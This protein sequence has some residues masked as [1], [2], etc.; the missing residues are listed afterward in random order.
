MKKNRRGLLAR[1]NFT[2][3]TASTSPSITA[4]SLEDSSKSAGLDFISVGD[5]VGMTPSRFRELNSNPTDTMF[6][7]ARAKPLMGLKHRLAK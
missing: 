4:F 1:R 3:A 5:F 6:C 2:K 7:M